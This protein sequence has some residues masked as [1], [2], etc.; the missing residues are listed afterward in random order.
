MLAVGI[1]GNVASGKTTVAD[2][3][4]DAGVPVIDAD[5]IGHAVLEEDAG[6]RDALV[7]EFGR[8]ILGPDGRIDRAALG[9]RAFESP[10]R[11]ARLNAIVHPPLLERLD[12]RIEAAREKG[13]PVVAVDAALLFEFNLDEAMDLVVLVTAPEDLR[14][15]RLRESRDLSQER[16]ERIM[17]S[18]LSDTEKLDGSDYVIVN[19]GT[20]ED[21]RARAD[22][23]LEEILNPISN[24]M[25]EEE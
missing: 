8:Q 11:T 17:A 10:E 19:D 22:E 24:R 25:E 12:Q 3:W 21:L 18:Q 20:L 16:I 9:E 4:R 13:H 6:A 5:R 23:V 7:Q 14:A 1:S 15:R 2:R